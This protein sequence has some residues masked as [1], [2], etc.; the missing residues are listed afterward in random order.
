MRA[1]AFA[2]FVSRVALGIAI[3]PFKESVL[4]PQQK[5]GPDRTSWQDLN[6]QGEEAFHRGEYKEA[7]SCF[8]PGTGKIRWL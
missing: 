6:H 7:E 1:R 2:F 5:K 4:N 3:E 8:E